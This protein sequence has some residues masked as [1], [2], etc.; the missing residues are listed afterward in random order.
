MEPDNPRD[1]MDEPHDVDEA[2]ERAWLDRRQK[3]GPLYRMPDLA[4]LRPQGL[5]AAFRP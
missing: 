3:R 4:A 5:D 2:F 1:E